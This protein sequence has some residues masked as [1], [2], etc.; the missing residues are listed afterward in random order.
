MYIAV[1]GTS[2]LSNM[3]NV[4]VVIVP[5]VYTSACASS[6]QS[7]LETNL[8]KG[9]STQP[10]WPTGCEFEQACVH[11]P[12]GPGIRGMKVSTHLIDSPH[13]HL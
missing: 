4:P 9:H 5:E 13:T 1:Q 2:T 6:A 3:P 7:T 11:L 10:H 12:P 8:T